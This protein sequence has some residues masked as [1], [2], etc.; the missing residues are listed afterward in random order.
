MSVIKNNLEIIH[1]KIEK[2]ALKAGRRPEEVRLIA[3]SKKQPLE[4]IRE[5]FS[6][7]QTIFGENYLQ[8]ALNKIDRLDPAIR[9]HFIGHLQSNKAALAATKFDMIHTVDRLKIARALDKSLTEGKVDSPLPVLVQVNIGREQQK[10]GVLPEDCHLL[11]ND[12]LKLKNI[13]A[14]GLM[15]M[16]PFSAD[17]EK[18]RPYFRQIRELAANLRE[19]GLLAIEG[20]MELSMGMSGDFET[21]IEEGATLVRVG[22]ALFGERNS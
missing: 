7:G 2:A 21:A 3:V 16:P 18:T 4:L 6:Y 11:L 20:K 1:N 22:T 15:A 17:P 8:E 19:K 10:S 12:I 14:Q 9:W 5:T 13:R